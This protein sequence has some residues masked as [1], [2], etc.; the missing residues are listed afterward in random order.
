VLDPNSP[1]HRLPAGLHR[2]QK[3]MLDGISISI[4][5]ATMSYARLQNSLLAYSQRAVQEP[6]SPLV[7]ANLAMMDAWM[8]IDAVNR[9]RVLVEA[10]RG[11][12]RGPAV[13]SFYRSVEDVETLRNAV[14]HLPG[15]VAELEKNGRPLWGTLSWVYRESPA[16]TKIAILLLVPGTI[17]PTEGLPMVNPLGKEVEAPIGLVTLFAKEVTVCLSDVVQAVER[18]AERLERAAATA[19]AALPA[20]AVD[21]YVT[22]DLP[23]D[24]GSPPAASTGT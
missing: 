6:P 20:D 10:T 5:M 3:L 8:I 22:L 11:L 17:A 2:R 13:E 16:A 24:P 1:L 18:F 12:K 23:V 7:L 21:E 15:E 4:D 9:L 14:Q 19:F